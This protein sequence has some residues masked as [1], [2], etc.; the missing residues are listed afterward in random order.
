[1]KP[2]LCVLVAPA[3]AN[4]TN[5]KTNQSDGHNGEK[6]V[7]MCVVAAVSVALVLLPAACLL[8]AYFAVIRIHAATC[9]GAARH[10]RLLWRAG[11]IAAVAARTVLGVLA[12]WQLCAQ[13]T[14]PAGITGSSSVDCSGLFKAPGRHRREQGQSTTTHPAVGAAGAA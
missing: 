3:P 6:N 5:A 12:G 4:D 14:P 2:S 8:I 11:T 9:I 1:M 10:E 13:P 7:E